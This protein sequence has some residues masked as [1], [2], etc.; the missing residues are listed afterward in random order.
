MRRLPRIPFN[1]AAVLSLLVCVVTTGM[2]ARSYFVSDYID[3]TRPDWKG[4]VRSRVG[5]L[6]IWRDN[7][8]YG[9]WRSSHG[10]VRPPTEDEESSLLRVY[11]YKNL[12]DVYWGEWELAIPFAYIVG[13][14]LI[15]PG[16]WVYRRLRRQRSPGE[17]AACGYDLR[18]T[19]DRCP[20]CGAVPTTNDARLPPPLEPGG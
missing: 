7:A 15:P 1:V 4:G 18:A 16:W 9:L 10:T 5:K 14:T 3:W 6:V 19:P 2:W 20:E 17:C 11:H 12:S 8:R 13:P